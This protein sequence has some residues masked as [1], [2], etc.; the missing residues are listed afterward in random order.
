MKNKNISKVIITLLVLAPI[1]IG[2]GTHPIKNKVPLISLSKGNK[3]SLQKK[4][5]EQDQSQQETYSIQTKVAFKPFKEKQNSSKTIFESKSIW[6]S[7]T[8]K[9]DPIF[10]IPISRV[11]VLE[12]REPIK[13]GDVIDLSNS[14]RIGWTEKEDSYEWHPGK[15]DPNLEIPIAENLS[16]DDNNLDNFG[17]IQIDYRDLFPENPAHLSLR[18]HIKGAKFHIPIEKERL[19]T[20]T[21]PP[22]SEVLNVPFPIYKKDIFYLLKR[23]LG[24]PFDQHWRYAEHRQRINADWRYA[25][26]RQNTI[27]QRRFHENIKT[28]RTINFVFNPKINKERLK[29]IVCNIRV[30]SG[31]LSKNKFILRMVT[32]WHDKYQTPVKISPVR[33]FKLSGLRLMQID[34]KNL[35]GHSYINGE[36][37]YLEEI[38]LFIPGSVTDVTSERFLDHLVFEKNEKQTKFL[39]AAIEKSTEN[40]IRDLNLF[41]KSS[42]LSQSKHRILLNLSALKRIIKYSTASDSLPDKSNLIERISLSVLP[43]NQELKSGINLNSANI[44]ISNPRPLFTKVVENLYHKWGGPF[45]HIENPEIL[46]WPSINSFFDFHN[47]KNGNQFKPGLGQ[48]PDM[49]TRSTNEAVNTFS[50]PARNTSQEINSIHNNEI[51]VSAEHPFSSSQIESNGLLITGKGKWVEI[52][53]LFKNPL[54]PNTRFYLEIPQGREYIESSHANLLPLKKSAPPITFSPNQS[55]KVYR[56][57]KN[58]DRIKIRLLLYDNKPYRITLGNMILFEPTLLNLEEALDFPILLPRKFQFTAKEKFLNSIKHSKPLDLSRTTKEMSITSIQKILTQFPLLRLDHRDFFSPILET[59]EENLFQKNHFLDLGVISTKENS[60]S[61]NQIEHPYWE[62]KTLFFNKVSKSTIDLPPKLTRSGIHS[63]PTHTSPWQKVVI[64]L[65]VFFLAAYLFK[66]NRFKKLTNHTLVK[67]K[68]GASLIQSAIKSLFMN[69]DSQYIFLNRFIG[70][71]I[72]VLGFARIFF[73]EN[74]SLFDLQLLY[75]VIIFISTVWHEIF[76]KNARKASQSKLSSFFFGNENNIIPIG[77]HL[78][79]TIS[80]TTACYLIGTLKD[81][82]SILLIIFNLAMPIYIYLPWWSYTDK[83]FDLF[84]RNWRPWILL[85]GIIDFLGCI[86]YIGGIT[87]SNL[88]SIFSYGGLILALTWH[89]HSHSALNWIKSIMSPIDIFSFS[90]KGQRN[91]F[92]ILVLLIP[93][94]LF[95]ILDLN[96][97]AEQLGIISFFLLVLALVSQFNNKYRSNPISKPTF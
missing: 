19:N 39:T 89:I 64:P 57:E 93:I 20:L 6:S 87:I 81:N 10:K 11:N 54:K 92:G 12:T 75:L 66:Y 24:L 35:I 72:I 67:V 90:E 82:Q 88:L 37:L 29:K 49:P 95:R 46:E 47:I 27:L 91:T 94:V 85:T 71:T 38:I 40:Y 28:L 22:P 16:L 69:M 55:F 31:R 84:R 65:I 56:P 2:L 86:A 32:E 34:L 9:I 14:K 3:A 59:F 21:P 61:L 96:R 83:L 70:V 78:L 5:F 63:Q 97:I 73:I 23:F 26:Y 18:V 60:V 52:E 77:I 36:P 44:L 50:H 13:I 68:L 74:P 79:T 76:F 33:F 62:I 80:L 1:V 15:S 4:I 8:R 43:K 17:G 51:Q 58:I 53:W 25:E 30:S 42:E 41:A 48:R 7:S 45:Y